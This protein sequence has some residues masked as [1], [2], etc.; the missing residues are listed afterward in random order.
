MGKLVFA[1]PIVFLI[2][3]VIFLAC[4][5]GASRYSHTGVEGEGRLDPYGC[6]QRNVQ[7]YVNPDYSQFFPLAFFFTIM[8]VLVLVV[9]TA[10]YDAP[11]LPIVF[12]A[13]GILAM[14]IISRR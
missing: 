10:P 11:L 6:G 1:P 8:H 13:S 3:V 5:R 7:D 4:S 9:A 14:R 12:V 2:F